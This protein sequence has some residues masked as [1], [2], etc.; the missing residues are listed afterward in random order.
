MSNGMRIDP[1]GLPL[2]MQEQVGVAIAENLAKATPV[3]GGEERKMLQCDPRVFA[4]CP[5]NRTCVSIDNARFPEGSDCDLFSQKVLAARITNADHIRTMTDRE[6]A[7]FLHTVTRAC[8]DHNC[9]GCPIG[10]ENC[11]VMLH[12]VKLPRKED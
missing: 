7:A 5:Y 11:I 12:W 1:K 10:Q 2:H 6:L 9:G 4:R 3:A 8:A